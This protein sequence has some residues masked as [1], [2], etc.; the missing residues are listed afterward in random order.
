MNETVQEAH[1]LRRV[2][3]YGMNAACADYIHVL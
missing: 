1:L 3:V 2:G